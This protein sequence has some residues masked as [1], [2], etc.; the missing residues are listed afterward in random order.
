M[1]GPSIELHARHAPPSPTAAEIPDPTTENIPVTRRYQ[2]LL[3]L[4][5][6]MMIFQIIGINSVFG[7]FQDFYT[8][9]DSNIP[10]ARGN[11]A[12]VALVGTIGSGLT[13]S[14]GIFVNPILARVESVKLITFA[15]A[16]IMSLGLLLASFSSNLWQLFATQALL[17]GIGSSLYYFPI[18]TIAPTYFD[19]HRGFAMGCILSGAGIGGLVMAPVLQILLDK[20]GIRGALRILALWNF[21][22][23]FP[24][25]CVARRRSGFDATART[26]VNMA[27]VKRGTFL[28]QAIGA[29]LQ[30]AGNVIPLYYMTSY[31]TSILS[32]SRSTGSLLLA[33]NSGVNSVARIGMGVLADH[34]GR[35]NTMICSPLCPCLPCGTNAARERFIVFVV[36]Y[37]I[38]A[39]GYNA[40][41]PTTITEIYGV[42]NYARVNGSIYFIRGLGSLLGAPIAGL[43]LGSYKRGGSGPGVMRGMLQER[44]DR[45]VVY[46]GL[47]LFCAGICVA[48]VRWLDARD[49]G[50]WKWKA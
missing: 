24:V 1:A 47:L 13:W 28:Y 27:L 39:G 43:I 40:L 16:A 50:G 18:M 19:R 26:R 4:S 34:V 42:E 2:G 9:E 20:Y 30:A 45:V 48:Y 6:F 31:S 33:V 41:V 32:Y 7:I 14:G 5:G 15:G 36:M 35:Q 17:Y 21:V 46:D 29:F 10:S 12:I 11:D 25:A 8:S 49:K 23:G 22:V 44:Y 38:Y 37:G 3:L